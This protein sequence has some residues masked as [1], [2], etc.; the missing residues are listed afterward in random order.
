MADHRENIDET[1]KILILLLYAEKN[2]VTGPQARQAIEMALRYL[3]RY[4]EIRYGNR[5]SLVANPK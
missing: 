3:L 4:R 5:G 2:T 1:I